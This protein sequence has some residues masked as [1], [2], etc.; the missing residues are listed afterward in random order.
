[1]LA[2]DSQNDPT[3]HG[4]PSDVLPAGQNVLAEHATQAS[5]LVAPSFGLYVPAEQ[6]VLEAG[7]TQ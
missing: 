5:A 7:V 1:M 6:E 2:G 4:K 3:G